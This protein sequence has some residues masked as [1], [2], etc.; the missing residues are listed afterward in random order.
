MT[1]DAVR[2]SLSLYSGS[3][4]DLD[5]IQEEL[6][7]RK[8][9][10]LL[11]VLGVSAIV[12]SPAIA[13]IK[14]GSFAVQNFNRGIFN[15]AEAYPCTVGTYPANLGITDQQVF[16]GNP[17][18]KDIPGCLPAAPSVGAAPGVLC[19]KRGPGADRFCLDV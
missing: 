2:S 11:A 7:V 16:A 8:S 5:S 1:V 17:A 14:S 12:T 3:R 15:L 6:K 18:T 19:L 4:P 9:L 13:Q 10:R